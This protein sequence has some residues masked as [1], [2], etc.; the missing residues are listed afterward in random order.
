MDIEIFIRVGNCHVEDDGRVRWENS[1]QRRCFVTCEN[2]T[3]GAKS[4]AIRL[5]EDSLSYLSEPG[6]K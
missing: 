6:G 4:E 5:V 1:K 2:Y 3:E